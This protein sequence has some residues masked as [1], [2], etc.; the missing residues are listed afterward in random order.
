MAKKSGIEDFFGGLLGGAVKDIKDRKSKLQEA[1]DQ[2]MS[3]DTEAA[4]GQK[5]PDQ[6]KKW[7][8]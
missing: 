4:S 1:E 5:R 7:V 3:G 6:S 8:E 2:A